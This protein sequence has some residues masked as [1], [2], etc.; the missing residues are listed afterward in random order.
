VRRWTN[1]RPA[2]G[3]DAAFDRDPAFDRIDRR[4]SGAFGAL[5]A[6]ILA[7]VFVAGNLVYIAA[8]N[9]QRER[10]SAVIAT[11]LRE[12]LARVAFSGR[13]H[14]RLL[15]EE[16]ARAE[17]PIAYVRVVSPD[18]LVLADSDPSRNGTQ[19]P[20]EAV[21]EG[22]EVIA[23]GAL[24]SVAR[25]TADGPVSELVFPLQSGFDDEVV[26][27]VRIGVQAESPAATVLRGSLVIG[28]GLLVLLVIAFP[29]LRALSRRIGAPVKRLASEMDGILRHAPLLISVQDREGR[30]ERSSAALRAQFGL[31]P[32]ARPRLDE[33]LP[34]A[35]LPESTD[36]AELRI[37]SGGDERLFQA[38]RFPV[39]VGPD[40]RPSRTCLIAA[41]ITEQRRALA[42]RDRLA[43][44]VE[45]AGDLI[46][47]TS[48]EG[49]ITYANRAFGESTG[50]SAAELVGETPAVLRAASTPPATFDEVTAA[51]RRGETWRG[52]I[53]TRGKAGREFLCDL[54][55][56]PVLGGD[57]AALADVWIGRDVSRE[58]QLEQQLLRSQ[59]MDA[60]GRLAGGIAHDFN[61][62][63]TVVTGMC[64]LARIEPDLPPK[65]DELLATIESAGYRGADLT[66]KL[67]AFSRRQVLDLKPLDLNEVVSGAIRIVQQAVGEGIQLRFEPAPDLW[68]TRADQGQVE[69]ILL[70]LAINARDAMGEVG[71]ISI[72]TANRTFGA[73]DAELDPELAPGEFV[74]LSVTDSG[75]GI[76]KALQEKVF[77]PFFTTKQPGSGTGL[78]LSIV[79]GIVRQSGGFIRLFS[80]P[81]V[82]TTFRI[83]FPRHVAVERA[84]GTADVREAPADPGGSETL[85]V[86]E[87]DPDVRKTLVQ[88]LRPVGYRV[89]EAG[90]GEQALAYLRS[91]AR[92][93]DLVL[94]DLVM[95]R[96]GGLAL[97]TQLRGEAPGLPVIFLSGYSDAVLEPS[98]EL[99][100]APLLQKP[101]SVSALRR[102]V[103][104]TL[105]AARRRRPLR[106]VRPDEA[107]GGGGS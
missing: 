50:W 24:R 1:S 10:L 98:A 99:R 58:V 95:P 66:R 36:R 63:L 51:V 18:G 78:G 46:L 83:A 5:L 102:V 41:D 37:A 76:P 28:G 48:P 8:A 43:T 13:H 60:V 87:D 93:P 82:G 52:R 54:T 49:R 72:E 57:G 81:G 21:A 25:T 53:E 69:Q 12:S 4:M 80:E 7:A 105:D 79:D 3:A 68:S 91:A 14:I 104:D 27:V 100:G 103:R 101:P 15:V 31:S 32:D 19:E 70:N 88:S 96:M 59:K 6:T 35:A 73:E 84:R 71:R 67:L 29:L 75:A 23:S 56:S 44:A 11:T 55:V 22:A 86:V 65:V 94:T 61:N 74:V 16:I 77:E 97:A 30:V 62:L 85:L 45:F 39:E 40:G 106:A 89:V 33:L 107:T 92:R 26:G 2:S 38:S 90:D 20:P 17:A 34:A 64:S 47:I 9:D 42:E